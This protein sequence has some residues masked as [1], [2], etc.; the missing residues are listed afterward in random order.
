MMFS[1]IL[2][3]NRGEIAVRIIRAC[4]ELGIPS[5]AVYSESDS[6]ALHARLADEALPIGPSPASES[7]LSI[8]KILDAARRSNAQAIHPGYGFLSENAAFAKAV[9]EAGITFIGPPPEAILAMGDKAQARA[10]MLAAGV[11]GV[12]GHQGQDDLESLQQAAG[13]I[14]YPALVKAAAGGG[15]KGMRVVWEENELSEA[16]AAARRE[17]QRAFGDS[18]IILER[19]I[20][21][22]HH[23]EFQVLADGQGN[24]VHLF[25]R[26]CSVQRRH[27]KVIEETPSPLLDAAL[28]AEMGAAAIRVAEAIGYRNAGTVEFIV[29]PD[30][31]EFYFLEMN[32]RLQVEHPVTEFVTGL[33]LVHWQIRIAAGEPLP[34]S[35]S[36]LEQRGHAIECRLYAEDPS[37]GFLPA[38]GTL[39]RFV[40]PR[41]PGVRVDSGFTS[42][43][44]ITLHYD[45]LIAKIIAYAENRPAAIRK[46]QSA[47]RETVLLGITSNWQFLLDVL[48]HPDF[49]AGSVFT[50]WVENHFE[51]WRPPECPLPPEVL[52]AAA[53]T[54]FRATPGASNSPPAFQ[55]GQDPYSPWHITNGFRTG[56]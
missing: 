23:V 17:A 36:E 2:I 6:R 21:H 10:S 19:Y 7:Y 1:K 27:Q 13:K 18:R 3:A 48:A 42:G 8:E 22:A 32:T 54:Q 51:D 24:T 52:V 38:T 55:S 11:P 40:E 9:Q 39:L 35:Q 26:E 25:E 56:E 45:P 49:R 14:G 44:E 47:L 34:F 29:D 46:L 37:N 16:V 43:D 4:R 15:G 5:V 12:P 28:R 31:R 50:T 53:L 33:D 41:S 30:T 20:P